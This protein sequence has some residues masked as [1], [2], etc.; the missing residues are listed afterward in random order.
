ME[1][2]RLR[3]WT[4]INNSYSAETY[5]EARILSCHV[6]VVYLRHHVNI[7]VCLVVLIFV[8]EWEIKRVWKEMLTEEASVYVYTIHRMHTRFSIPYRLYPTYLS[9]L[10]SEQW[11][12]F[13][14]WQF[15]WV[16]S[17]P[18]ETVQWIKAERKKVMHIACILIGYYRF[19]GNVTC[20]LT[21]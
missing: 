6:S 13:N 21:G 5:A 19:H 18:F 4:V 20:L 8:G 10:Y 15:W 1:G 16:R 9:S 17:D 12:T 2:S 14:A 7:W 3:N 11:N